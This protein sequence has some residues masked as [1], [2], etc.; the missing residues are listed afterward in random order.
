[1]FATRTQDAGH[2]FDVVVA[3]LHSRPLVSSTPS[4]GGGAAGSAAWPSGKLRSRNSLAAGSGC[5]ALCSVKLRR[6]DAK[7]G[8]RMPAGMRLKCHTGSVS[9]NVMELL[10]RHS[11]GLAQLHRNQ[12]RCTD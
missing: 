10:L 9:L 1:M 8:S 2:T 4:A 6:Y 12:A 3:I 11:C 5:G 7:L